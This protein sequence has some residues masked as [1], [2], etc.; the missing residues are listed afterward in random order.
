MTLVTL[1]K[2]IQLSELDA[3]GTVADLGSEILVDATIGERDGVRK[4]DRVIAVHRAAERVL[5][6]ADSRRREY[7]RKRGAG[8]DRLAI[9]R[10]LPSFQTA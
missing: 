4:R 3:W 8:R 2:D 1:K 6:R 9:G 5:P 7:R 10:V